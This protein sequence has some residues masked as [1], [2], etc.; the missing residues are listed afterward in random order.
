MRLVR[1]GLLSLIVKVANAALAVGIAVILARSLGASDFGVYS[2]V[3]AMVTVLAIPVQFGLPQFLVRETTKAELVG[4]VNAMHVVWRWAHLVSLLATALVAIV[5]AAYCVFFDDSERPLLLFALGFVLVPLYA[6]GRLRGAALRGLGYTLMGQLPDTL[7]RPLLLFLM[8][9]ALLYFGQGGLDSTT[10]VSLNVASAL[11]AFL[12]GALLLYWKAPKSKGRIRVRAEPG[13]LASAGMLGS[14]G[15]LEI[16]NKNLDL[17]M[18]GQF[19]SDEDVGIYRISVLAAG[20]AAFGLQAIN[21]TVMRSVSRLYSSGDMVGLQVLTRQS[22][23][24][25]FGFGV[26][27]FAVLA[28][29]GRHILVWLFGDEF[30][31]AYVPM[32]VL[33][34]GHVVF[35]AFGAAGVLLTMSGNERLAMSS[36]GV[37]CLANIALNLVLIPQYGITGAAIATTATY[38]IWS[39]VLALRLYRKTG[40]N[41]FFIS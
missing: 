5:F 28:L 27:L 10:A 23:Q 16:L 12:F 37:A 25:V 11:A 20:T 4:D 6:F 33:T 26:V 17:L 14:L 34:F 36:A 1:D 29:S 22:S 8:L 15:G 30:G 18:I 13:W 9:S 7:V 32:M 40:I 2:Y 31:S 19:M 3:L 39:A 38:G 41:S 24:L 35:A 21:V